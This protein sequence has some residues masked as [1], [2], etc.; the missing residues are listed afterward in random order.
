M[1]DD[2]ENEDSNGVRRCTACDRELPQG[3]DVT[4]L[5]DGVIGPRGFVPLEEMSFFCGWACLERHFC[6]VEVEKLPR[7]IP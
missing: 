7:R 4:A 3:V 2:I 1:Y 6:D 5:Q